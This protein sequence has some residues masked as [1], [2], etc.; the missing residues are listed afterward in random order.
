MTATV[1][2]TMQFQLYRDSAGIN[3]GGLI[4]QSPNLSGWNSS[5]TATIVV[6]KYVGAV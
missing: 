6:D 4:S 3:N 2:M 1:G 5:P